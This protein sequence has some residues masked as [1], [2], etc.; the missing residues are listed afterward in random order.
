MFYTVLFIVKINDKSMPLN[1]LMAN[2]QKYLK[3]ISLE[4]A[5]FDFTQ[6]NTYIYVFHE[7]KL[8]IE[9]QFYEKNYYY[10]CNFSVFQFSKIVTSINT[11]ILC[12]RIISF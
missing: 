9:L 1:V 3:S 4:L 6:Y 5:L 2:C 10:L 12:K 7:Q 11:I 8:Y